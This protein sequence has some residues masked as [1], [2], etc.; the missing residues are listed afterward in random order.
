MNSHLFCQSNVKT[1]LM[2]SRIIR[3][4]LCNDSYP[5]LYLRNVLGVREGTLQ[6]HNRHTGLKYHWPSLQAGRLN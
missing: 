6:Y 5:Y 3:S 2:I 4:N 1:A